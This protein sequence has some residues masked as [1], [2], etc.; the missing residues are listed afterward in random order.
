MR[1]V[2][3]LP[4]ISATVNWL[5]RTHYT[6]IEI[7]SVCKTTTEEQRLTD[8][9]PPPKQSLKEFLTEDQ[10]KTIEGY[11]APRRFIIKAKK[12]G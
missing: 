6:D 4:S 7:L 3:F 5:A 11:P 10:E 8:W 2:W 1:N 12:K 9:C